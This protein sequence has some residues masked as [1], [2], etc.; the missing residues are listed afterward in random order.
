MKFSR[1][2]FIKLI[3]IVA[4][5]VG[6]WWFLGQNTKEPTTTRQV[7][8]TSSVELQSTLMTS[9]A[10]GPISTASIVTQSMSTPEAFQFP[11]TWNGELPTIINPD[12]YR[13]KIEGDV[14]NPLNL[15]LSDLYAMTSVQ[16]TVEIR[17][18]EGWV[19]DVP[20]EGIPL[21]QLL[22][23]AGASLENI[24]RLTIKA[25]SGYVT[26]LGSDDVANPDSMI[27][28]KVQGSTLTVDHGYPARLVAPT[29][30]GLDWVKCVTTI[31][32]TSN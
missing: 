18:V 24:A 3:P 25:A 8:E 31:T 14:P 1:R 28:L 23:Q 19:A 21:A 10:P 22:R 13:L 27:A 2:S 4:V 5:A 11:T 30:P 15:K 17:C 32:C 29:R 16:K 20:W 7:A 6:L 26:T 12:D 9:V